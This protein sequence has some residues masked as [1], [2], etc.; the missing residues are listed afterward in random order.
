MPDCDPLHNFANDRRP[1][2]LYVRDSKG[3]PPAAYIGPP[4]NASPAALIVNEKIFQTAVVDAKG[5]E[6]KQHINP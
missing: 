5:S 4:T 3:A 2:V 1:D 6:R